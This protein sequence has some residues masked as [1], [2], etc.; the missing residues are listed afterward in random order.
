MLLLSSVFADPK[1][2]C[3]VTMPE[4]VH[5]SLRGV[6]EFQ[7]KRPR[8]LTCVTSVFFRLPPLGRRWHRLPPGL[9]EFVRMPELSSCS[10]VDLTIPLHRGLQVRRGFRLDENAD[11]GPQL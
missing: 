3:T 11:R 10:I 6:L 1:P 7:P 5:R 8:L 4:S 2:V 9:P